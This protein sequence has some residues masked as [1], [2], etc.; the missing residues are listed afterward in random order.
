[1]S[2]I[3]APRRSN[4]FGKVPT[5]ADLVDGEMGVNVVDGKIYQRS[6]AF[7]YQVGSKAEGT[8]KSVGIAPPLG[9]YSLSPPVIDSG[10]VEFHWFQP[11]NTPDTFLRAQGPLNPPSW[12]KLTNND[13]PYE[14]DYIHGLS[15][16]TNSTTIFISAGRAVI[17]TP[18]NPTVFY[19]GGSITSSRAAN[20]TYHLYLDSTGAVT[21]STIAPGAPY[22][23]SARRRG[24]VSTTRYLGT[25]FTDSSGNYLPQKTRGEGNSVYTQYLYNV[26]ASGVILAGG[27]DVTATDVSLAGRAPVTATDAEVLAVHLSSAGVVRLYNYN[28]TGFT[29]Y[30][31]IDKPNTQNSFTVSLDSTPKFQYDAVSGGVAWIY[32]LGYHYLR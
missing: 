12:T 21:R 26:K 29:V 3:I 20:T 16:S 32:L 4:V 10:V 24:T 11:P 14:P 1:M 22:Y 25:V 30:C 2:A 5:T 7:V 23:L 13:I 15:V 27:T 18:N 28:N 9:F 6:G 17:P 8:V 31:N 19:A